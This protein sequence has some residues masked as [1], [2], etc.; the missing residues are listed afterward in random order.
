MTSTDWSLTWGFRSGTNLIVVRHYPARSGRERWFT[1]N[2]RPSSGCRPLWQGSA[3]PPP[4]PA[5]RQRPDWRPGDTDR[6]GKGQRQTL[7]LGR[8]GGI[9]INQISLGQMG[10][11]MPSCVSLESSSK[12]QI[13]VISPTS[14][15]LKPLGSMCTIM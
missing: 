2:T 5:T 1:S 4:A 3:G 12:D 8:V 11:C 7:A 9:E 14:L 10:I 15:K 13:S 6:T